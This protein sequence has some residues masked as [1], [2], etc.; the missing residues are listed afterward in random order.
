VA[1]TFFIQKRM[2]QLKKGLK[3]FFLYQSFSTISVSIFIFFQN[4]VSIVLGTIFLILTI[5]TIL[6]FV[7]NYKKPVKMKVKQKHVWDLTKSISVLESERNSALNQVNFLTME[8]QRLRTLHQNGMFDR[9]YCINCGTNIDHGF[10]FCP[11]CGNELSKTT[12][13][14]SCNVLLS[15]KEQ[16]CPNCGLKAQGD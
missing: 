11:K 2:L 10:E 1:I 15:G 7:K 13:C 8:N 14:T 16:F 3:E 5:F 9:K 12:N 4:Q 6:I